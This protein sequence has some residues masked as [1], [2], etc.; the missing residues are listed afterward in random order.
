MGYF[1]SQHV[2][3]NVSLCSAQGLTAFST[4]HFN[5]LQW[6]FAFSGTAS[7]PQMLLRAAFPFHCCP[8]FEKYVVAVADAI[9]SCWLLFCC[10]SCT[11]CCDV[12]THLF[13]RSQFAAQLAPLKVPGTR[14]YTV[15]WTGPK[16]TSSS[17][18]LTC[19]A[20]NQCVYMQNQIIFGL[21]QN[22]G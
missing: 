10:C 9:V 2:E 16:C 21:R 1:A 18:L 11:F 22:S 20:N 6:I 8:L 19:V 12:M 5:F 13:D 15:F 4:T 17:L 3:T 7:S 14:M